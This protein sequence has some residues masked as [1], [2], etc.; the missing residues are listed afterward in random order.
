MREEEIIKRCFYYKGGVIVPRMYQ[1]KMEHILWDAERYVCNELFNEI[2]LKEPEKSI[3]SYV[4]AYVSKWEPFNYHE[5]IEAYL[6]NI[7]TLREDIL[8]IYN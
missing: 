6:S 1:R 4:A 2:D 5:I 8:S 3:A 7:P